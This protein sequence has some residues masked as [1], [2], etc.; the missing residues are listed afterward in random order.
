M[1][2]TLTEYINQLRIVNSLPLI[3]NTDH[4]LLDIALSCGF[5]SYKTY[6]TA[7]KKLFH[8]T[9]YAWQKEQKLLHSRQHTP[10]ETSSTF[11]F[12][13]ITGQKKQNDLCRIQTK[14]TVSPWS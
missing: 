2:L 9:P 11:S 6:N 12:S 8:T 7:F 3:M 4:S 5:N 1:G 13:G 14:M 10:E